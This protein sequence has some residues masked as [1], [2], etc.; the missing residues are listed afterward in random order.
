[1]N[2]NLISQT[3]NVNLLYNCNLTKNASGKWEGSVRVI[4]NRNNESGW[5]SFVD[6]AYATVT[7]SGGKVTKIAIPRTY[8]SESLPNFNARFMFDKEGITPSYYVTVESV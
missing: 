8:M 2:D 6:G 5:R 3:N 7:I 1:M 4:S